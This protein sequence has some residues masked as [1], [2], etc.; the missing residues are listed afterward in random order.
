MFDVR[1][2]ELHAHSSYS[3]LDGASSPA[4]L[5]ERAAELELRALALTES[6]GLPSVVSLDRAVRDLRKDGLAVPATVFGSEIA[7][8]GGN[9]G[10]LAAQAEGRGGRP[11]GQGGARAAA[12]EARAGGGAARAVLLVGSPQGYAALS[13]LLAN[14]ALREESA[15]NVQPF[16]LAEVAEN[17]SADWC[18][19][20]GTKHGPLRRALAAGGRDGAARVLD[21]MVALLGVER[22]AVELCLERGPHDAALTDALVELATARGL[23]VVA[24][25]AAR[26]ATAAQAPLAQAL[27]ATRQ[28]TSL[29]EGE[30]RIHQ[31]PPVLRSARQMLALHHR[32]PAAVSAAADL[33]D[34]LAFDL[35]LLA[36]RLPSCQVPA[37]HT[38]A[39]WLRFLTEQGARARYGER[40]CHPQAW[41]MIDHE[42]EVICALD[43]P[44]YF[45]IVHDIVEFCRRNDILC[46]GRGS[47]ANSAVCY[48]LG[49]TAVD[50]VTHKLLFERFLSP[51]RS[52]PPDIDLDIESGRREEVIQYVYTRYGRERAAM[53]ANVITYR[54][55]SA[56]RDAAKALGYGAAQA[57]AW[58]KQMERWSVPTEAP[59]GMPAPVLDLARQ[60]QD[61]PR[62]FG[63]HPGGMVLCDRPVIEV[64]P[65]RWSTMPGRTVLQWDKDDCA[66]AGLVKF[67]LLGLGMLTALRLAFTSLQQRGITVERENDGARQPLSLHNLPP[68]DLGVYRLLRAA[69]TVGVFQVE[70]RAQMQTL[71]RLAPECFYDIVA[72]VALIRPGPIQGNAVHPY[73]RRRRGREK[74]TYLHPLL[75]PALEKTL[76]VPLFQE[77]L[78]QIA[79]DAAGFSP[80]QADQLRKAMGA[81]RSMER[82]ERLRAQAMA[83]MDSKGIEPQIAAEIF[84]LLR[85]FASFGFPESHSFSFAY[86]VYAS[87]WL[88]V[89]HPED[90][91]AGLLGAQPMGFYSPASLVTDFER[92]GVRVARPCVQRSEVEASVE[93]VAPATPA[94][95]RDAPR[96]PPGRAK[97]GDD[98]A[99]RYGAHLPDRQEV[100][101]ECEQKETPA[102]KREA[103]PAGTG[104]SEPLVHAH[105][106][107]Q[108]RLGLSSL[109][110]IGK[111][112][113]GRIVEERQRAGEFASFADLASRVRLS[114]KQKEALA[115]SGA[116]RELGVTRREGIWQ[117]GA[118]SSSYRGPAAPGG[119][120]QPVLPGLEMGLEAPQLPA[121]SV[122]Q[123]LRLD[124]SVTGASPGLHPISLVRAQLE[125]AGIRPVDAL[126]RLAP[127][128]YAVAGLVTHRQRPATAAGT[129]F[130]ALE[131]ETGIVNITC[132]E[133]CWQRYKTVARRAQA[134]VVRGKLEGGDGA[135]GIKAHH[136]QEL[137]LGMPV[138]ARNFR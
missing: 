29:R 74:V 14:A 100:P 94:G 118:L 50:A 96:R 42:L 78:M 82:M 108:V 91:L 46:Q 113:A 81:K 138:V 53:V 37:G 68:E 10:Q 76:G 23:R 77:Q 48:A 99:E 22:V 88:K 93:M 39:S 16:Q 58:S 70:S 21:E 15:S 107:L 72:E 6:T 1:Y 43:F 129:V 63:V 123:T 24:T 19:L 7:L 111:E 57:E 54:G 30:G 136:L 137:E 115:D 17:A 124:L 67:D 132:T 101:R 98:S 106:D 133:G 134:L 89:H 114:T 36:P 35:S 32:H 117:A 5:V 105:P 79:I 64:C 40:A 125:A 3:F 127:G 2:A 128:N 8:A 71:P 56:V 110:G 109:K 120:Y 73:I 18:L 112:L 92:F 69:Q 34:E 33:A 102:G 4:Q 87:A 25:T 83:G 13:R 122:A 116:L 103:P 97:D 45:L 59:E 11:G 126:K 9:V 65:V 95:K 12:D 27:G 47:A 131:D 51:G 104:E 55:R 62:H 119:S 60:Y 44:G 52:G 41:R 86:L 90:L 121:P 28:L 61:L 75:Q 80:A 38:D 26:A 31:N 84:E 66:D 49:I 135:L 20:T 85:A 130:L